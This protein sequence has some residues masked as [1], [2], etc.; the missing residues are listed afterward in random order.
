MAVVAGA[1]VADTSP[2]VV[3]EPEWVPDQPLDGTRR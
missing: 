3:D 1:V 2:P